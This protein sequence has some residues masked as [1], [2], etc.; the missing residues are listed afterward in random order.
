MNPS[1]YLT[2]SEEALS[3]QDDFENKWVGALSALFGK[4]CCVGQHCMEKSLCAGESVYRSS[5]SE[6]EESNLKAFV[7]SATSCSYYTVICPSFVLF[8]VVA[9]HSSRRYL[10]PT[11][12]EQNEFLHQYINLT[13]M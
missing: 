5:A 2:R 6:N 12:L 13:F 3:L 8:N 9:I 11:V 7:P 10:I 1:F 4:A